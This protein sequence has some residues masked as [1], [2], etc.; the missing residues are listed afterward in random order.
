MG[1]QKSRHS[2]QVSYLGYWMPSVLDAYLCW[3]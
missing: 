1:G 3:E 2:F